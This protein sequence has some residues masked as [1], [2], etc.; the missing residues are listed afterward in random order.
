MR[1]ATR[2]MAMA[3]VL[4]LMLTLVGTGLVGAHGRKL[5][6]GYEFVFGAMDEP[7]VTGQRTW[8]SVSV[9]DA[10]TK[11][12]TQGLEADEN[13]KVTL[14][15][16]PHEKTLAMRRVSGTP[17]SYK[18]AVWFTEAGTYPVKVTG[19]N[20]NTGEAFALD[21][22][23][24]VGAGADLY[25]PGAATAPSTQPAAPA[26]PAAPVDISLQI[27]SKMM[28][29][30]GRSQQMDVA[31]VILDGRTVVPLRFISEALGV[32]VHWDGATQSIHLGPQ[33]AAGMPA[34][35]AAGM[36]A[37]PAPSEGGHKDEP[38]AHGGSA[39]PAG[40]VS[41]TI[42]LKM[43]I[44]GFV[45]AGGDIDGVKNPVLKVKH[46]ETIKVDLINGDPL[47][48]DF[49]ID[50]L[51]AH[52]D[53]VYAEGERISTTFVASKDGSFYYYCSVPGHRKA[54]ME[55]T[56]EVSE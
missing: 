25:A 23:A 45:G 51:G 48:H 42:T 35:P 27:G 4:A 18:A 32:E 44:N 43:F 26:Q 7:M 33:P 56:I 1:K 17:G 49:V 15:H 10:T 6:A 9:N 41:Q 30:G 36:P 46:G 53:H 24:K 22:E 40:P 37:M 14:T 38:G 11:E 19:K 29:A 28:M 2:I 8:L 54:G 34:A 31:P 3:I 12:P 39:A 20:P 52:T 50:E 13:L 5:A 21:F 55:G 16:G 47:E